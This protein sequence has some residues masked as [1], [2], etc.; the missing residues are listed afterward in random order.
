LGSYATV[1]SLSSSAPLEGL[2]V[3]PFQNGM[4]TAIDAVA[5]DP[6]G[7]IDIPGVQIGSRINPKVPRPI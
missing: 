3:P 2:S 1:S 5:M 7:Q 6:S 4:S